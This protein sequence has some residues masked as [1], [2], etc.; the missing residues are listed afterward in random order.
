MLNISSTEIRRSVR[1]N[2]SVRFLV[3]D[4]VAAYIDEN[5]LY[6]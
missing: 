4:P 1:E 5:R 2:R 3:P 6:R